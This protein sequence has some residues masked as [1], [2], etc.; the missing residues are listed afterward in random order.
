VLLRFE[1]H[2]GDPAWKRFEELCAEASFV[3]YGLGRGHGHD[4]RIVRYD[5][6]R[7]RG[8]RDVRAGNRGTES[9]MSHDTTSIADEWIDAARRWCSDEEELNKMLDILTSAFG[10]GFAR[11]GPRGFWPEHEVS[12]RWKHQG[13][14]LEIRRVRREGWMGLIDG[15]QVAVDADGSLFGD[16]AEEAMRHLRETQE[17]V[18]A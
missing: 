16:D 2:W 9:R 14:S 15:K 18:E 5:C 7:Q 1:Q 11:S 8:W 4:W 3:S 13:R 10:L 12:F 6:R 17:R